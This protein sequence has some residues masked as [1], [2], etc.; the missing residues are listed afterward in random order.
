MFF[1]DDASLQYLGNS[2]GW[3]IGS[4]PSV[5]VLEE[6]FGKSIT[7]TTLKKEV[8]AIIFGQKGLMGG[9]GLQGSKITRITPDP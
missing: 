9:I 3:E 5:V 8:Y 4:G 6:G 7:T 1:M 2:K